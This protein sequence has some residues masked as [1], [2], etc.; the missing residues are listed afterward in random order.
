M[1]LRIAREYVWTNSAWLTARERRYVYDGLLPVQFRDENNLPVLTFT[2]GRDLSGA[3]PG[4]GTGAGGIGGLLA[5][6]EHLS[7]NQNSYYH[8]DGN[9]NVTVLVNNNQVI[10]ARYAYDPYGNTRNMSGPKADANLFRFSSKE[11]H[12]RSG[13]Y[14]YGY[15]WY[16]PELQRWLN[17]DPFQE[18]GGYGLYAFVGNNPLNDIDPFGLTQYFC[19]ATKSAVECTP[20][21]VYCRQVCHYHCDYIGWLPDPF[22]WFDEDIID[23]G[24]WT[25]KKP[26]PPPPRCHPGFYTKQPA[27]RVCTSIEG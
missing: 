14:Y 15:R 11:H 12:E 27:S 13:F 20:D 22:G 4:Q 8:C 18:N 7:P 10:V 5:F 26:V 6:T 19:Y 25:C 2:R 24:C 23:A 9:G 16:I 1:R 3:L 17:R 21:G